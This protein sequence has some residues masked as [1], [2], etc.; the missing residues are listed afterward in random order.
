MKP[1]STSP[2]PA[3]ARVAGALLLMTAAVLFVVEDRDQVWNFRIVDVKQVL[4]RG[5]RRDLARIRPALPPMS[6]VLFL[7][8]AFE[9][10]SYEP[11]YVVRLL[12]HDAGIVVDCAQSS[13]VAKPVTPAEYETVIQY[14]GGHYV[15]AGKS[16]C[17][18]GGE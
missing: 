16:A 1:L 18:T 8:H 14:C 5:L 10:D 15:E 12:Y 17:W 6:R 3:V 4:I 2:E 7:T 9:A 11:L 13:R